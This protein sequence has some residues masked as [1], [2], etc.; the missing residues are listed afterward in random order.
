M[1][2]KDC[3]SHAADAW[4][5][6]KSV[7]EL[8]SHPGNSSSSQLKI[9]PV[10]EL[11]EYFWGSHSRFA[12]LAQV[13]S[14]HLAADSRVLDAATGYGFLAETLRL[15]SYEASGCDIF[16]A[17]PILSQL[18]LPYV[19]WHLEAHPAPY[20]SGYFDG[21]VLSQ[22]IEHFTFSPR[23]PISEL[24]RITKPGGVLV[25]DAPNI[26]CFRNISRLLRGKS[27]HW[28]FM[29]HYLEQEPNIV[30]GVPYYDRHNH[31]YSESDFLD[32]AQFFNLSL[33]EVRYYSPHNLR[34]RG[35]AAYMFSV[36]RDLINRRWRKSLYAVYQVPAV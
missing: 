15:C 9:L 5:N 29:T 24:I 34:K 17:H 14:K 21:V 26:S 7:Y 3:K 13:I 12:L 16:E 32:I 4:G 18:G 19:C 22:A 8:L 30:D 33:L 11:E 36:L 10:H 31:E 27:L 1:N 6:I 28:N 23:H 35:K 2:L 25:I 20:E